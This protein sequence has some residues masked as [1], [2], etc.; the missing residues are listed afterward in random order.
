MTALA[1]VCFLAIADPQDTPIRMVTVKAEVLEFKDVRMPEKLDEETL[2]KFVASSKPESSKVFEL[3]TLN[4]RQARVSVGAEVAVVIG[5]VTTGKGRSQPTYQRT[6]VGSTLAVTPVVE[7]GHIKLDTYIEVSRIV[8]PPEPKKE[9]T[10]SRFVPSQKSLMTLEST[11]VLEPGKPLLQ[12]VRD[13]NPKTKRHY[14]I[15]IT[16]KSKTF[17]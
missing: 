17:K 6:D 11:L 5:F 3:S 16:V 4:Q 2:R 13:Q 9:T 1:L 15:V 8:D 7:K 12:H 14:V 10:G